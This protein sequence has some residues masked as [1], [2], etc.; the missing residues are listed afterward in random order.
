MS[1]GNNSRRAS[2]STAKEKENREKMD[3]DCTPNTLKLFE[4][5]SI[6]RNVSL[7]KENILKTQ[8]SQNIHMNLNILQE[9]PIQFTIILVILYPMDIKK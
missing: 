5:K 7:Q 4:D 6:S 1:K 2:A 3:L 8:E 9:R